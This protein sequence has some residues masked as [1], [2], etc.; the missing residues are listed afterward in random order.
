MH[1]RVGA[2]DWQ[3]RRRLIK[4]TPGPPLPSPPLSPDEGPAGYQPKQKPGYHRE[5]N[6]QN[7]LDICPRDEDGQT[8][9][10]VYCKTEVEM[11]RNEMKAG[12][13][14]SQAGDSI[15]TPSNRP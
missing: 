14:R 2:V 13:E 12:V 15:Q 5:S 4:S 6:V 8:G 10:Y 9:V 11:R 3:K 1:A 7:P